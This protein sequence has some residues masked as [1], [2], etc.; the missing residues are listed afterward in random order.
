MRRRLSTVAAWSTRFSLRLRLTVLT[1]GGHAAPGL[2]L[3]GQDERRVRTDDFNAAVLERARFGG[4]LQALAS[5]VTGGGVPLGRFDQLFLLAHMKGDADPG[6]FAWS[7]LEAQGQRIV[8][9]GRALE[10]AEDNRAELRA[11]AEAFHAGRL[12]VLRSL[13]VA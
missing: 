8:K 10:S 12:G 11:R 2:P 3:D 9:D 1:A 6:G 13:G 4:E 5:P 7:V